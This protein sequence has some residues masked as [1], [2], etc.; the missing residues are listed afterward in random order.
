LHCKIELAGLPDHMGNS[1][2]RSTGVGP[3]RA[4]TCEGDLLHRTV[5]CPVDCRTCTIECFLDKD[6]D[7]RFKPKK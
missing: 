5:D 1:D 3:C 4:G 2:W 7:I 6:H